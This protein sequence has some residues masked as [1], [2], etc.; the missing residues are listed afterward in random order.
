MKTDGVIFEYEIARLVTSD[1]SCHCHESGNL[2]FIYYADILSEL[3]FDA[4]FVI[5]VI[6]YPSNINITGPP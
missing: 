5:H 1:I 6:T 3:F 4:A 2:K